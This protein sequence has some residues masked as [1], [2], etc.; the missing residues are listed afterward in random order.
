M[1]KVLGLT[2]R[3]G[4]VLA[5]DDVG[6]SVDRGEIVGLLGPNGAGKTTT[7]A[8]VAG[9]LRADA[10]SI[11]I[12]GRDMAE[13][14]IGDRRLGSAPQEI[15]IYPVLTV[16]ENLE[17]FAQLA[18]VSRNQIAA[19]VHEA[20]ET[21]DLRAFANR[22]ARECSGGEQRRLHVATAL[23]GQPSLAL[24]DEPSA[25]LDVSSR[26]QL[27]EALRRL[28][29]S[30]SAICISSH[31]LD[32]VEALCERVVI[33]N[34]GR[35]VASGPVD[36]LL[37]DHAAPVI[38]LVFDDGSK[39]I[40]DTDKAEDLLRVLADLGSRLSDVSS[41]NVVRPSLEAAYLSMTGRRIVEDGNEE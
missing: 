6:F 22:R 25:G 16:K 36:G 34:E 11:T 23:I 19:A 31:Y 38:E 40:S 39:T 29:A 30:G 27:H 2:K 10:G 8:M 9:L 12:D 3:F 14:R 32:E 41:V 1:L 26:I 13:V 35:V 5:V 28:A 21:F 37:R 7:M 20:L 24:L 17:F 33:L 18:D 4:D 15:G